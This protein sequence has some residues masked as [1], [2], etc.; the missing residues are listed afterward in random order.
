MI[1]VLQ[2]N[3][4]VCRAAQDLALATASN[5]GTDVIVMSEPHRC[6]LEVDGW[7]SDTGGKAA[8]VLSNPRLQVQAIGPKDSAGFRWVKVEDLTVYTCYWSPN[9]VFTLFVDF[10]DRL[11][12]SIRQQTGTVIVAGDFNA[13]SP[14]WGDHNEDPKGRAL[15]DMTAS[16]GFIACNIGDKPTFSRVYAGGISRSHID[17]TFVNDSSSSQVQDWK[18]LDLYSASLHRYI[19]FNIT[20]KPSLDRRPPEERWSWRKY[21]DSKLREFINSTTIDTSEDALSATETL[22]MYLKQA[23]DSCMPKGRYSGGKKPVFWWSQE[24]DRLREECNK[25]RRRVKRRRLQSDQE[26]RL[27]EFRRARKELKVAIRNSKKNSWND[28]CKQVETDPWGL[29][30]KL[31]TKKLIGRRP[32]PGLSAPGRVEAI[33]NALFPREAAAVWPS[34]TGN[35]DFPAVTSTEV[36]ELSNRIPRGKA[37]GP[38]GVPDMIIRNVA[39]H[40]PE[41]MRDIFNMCLKGSVFPHSWKIA[42]LVLLRK[43]DKPLEDPS[44]YRPICLLNTIGKFF[45]RLIKTRIEKRLEETGELDDR[46]YGFRKGRSTVDAIRRVLDVVES[47]GSGQLYN[48]KLCAVVALDVANAFNSAKWLRIVESMKDKGMPPYLVGIIESYLSDR[49]VVH[50]GNSTPTTCGVPQGSVLGPLLWNIMYDNLLKVDT[51]GNVRGMSSTELV[52]FADDV[53]VVATGHTTWILETVTNQALNKVAEWMSG[54]GLSLSVRKTEAV[55]LTTKRGYRKP[56]F[57]I[58]GSHVE[59][60]ESIRYLGVELHRVLG[61]RAHVESAVA[62]AQ[63]TSTAL[64]RLMPNIGGPRQK[65]RSLLATVVT[66][67]LLYAAPIW[68]AAMAFKCNVT[69]LD[70]PQRT[71]AIRTIMA[72]RTVS[73]AAVLVIAGMIPAHLLAWERY[74]RYIRRHEPDASR[75][76]SELRAE[77]LRKWQAEWAEEN[78]GGWTRRLI[79]DISAWRGRKHGLVDFHMTQLLSNHGCFAEY[80]H[81]IGKLNAAT[82]VDC[83]GPVDDAEHV[84]FVCGRWWKQRRALEV[85]LQV[86]LSPDNIVP[87][88][89]KKR[90]NWEAVSRFV[91]LV[92]STR[93]HEERMRQRLN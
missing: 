87:T 9:T 84:F 79:Q 93:E 76:S 16:L 49:T 35:H 60:K 63:I 74:E 44:S 18:V 66:S 12:G 52:A 39:R 57:S 1:R 2:I 3:V 47:A 48:R 77:T 17:I 30:Y 36:I 83:Q 72:Y 38:D 6:G 22:D 42:K 91:N 11:E 90:S 73:T 70:R 65:K 89:L 15:V 10:L 8:I 78:N 13:K 50:G 4:G 68:G 55:V 43:G 21:D 24:I 92:Q 31:V 54:A 34:R 27:E 46:Q 14:V 51:G 41:I 32:I 80:L 58:L 59:L 69:S 81:R 85:E 62:S 29:P 5:M 71:I 67:K 33:V 56:N 53:A 75:T 7:Y 64:S 37:P 86:D 23:C 61:F 45:E 28:L 19:A 25:T 20:G 26:Q 40:K 88:M 82:C